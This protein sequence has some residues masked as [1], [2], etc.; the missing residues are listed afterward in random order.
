MGFAL[1]QNVAEL[2]EDLASLS[3]VWE[4]YPFTHHC[5]LVTCSQGGE[6]PLDGACSCHNCHC[7]KLCVLLLLSLSS[8]SL[9]DCTA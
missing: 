6:E 2:G 5:L 1:S 9:N 8:G 4:R 3:A 7:D